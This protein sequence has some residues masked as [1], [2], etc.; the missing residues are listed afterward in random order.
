MEIDIRERVYGAI[1]ILLLFTSCSVPRQDQITAEE[2]H[3]VMTSGLAAATL[4]GETSQLFW[5]P[6]L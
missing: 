3:S 1:L 5:R 6:L 4:I 2:R